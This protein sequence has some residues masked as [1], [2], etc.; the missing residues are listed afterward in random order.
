MQFIPVVLELSLEQKE[1]INF[2]AIK[3]SYLDQLS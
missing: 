1:A 2:L 3:G